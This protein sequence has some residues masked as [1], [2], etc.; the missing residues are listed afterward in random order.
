MPFV[1]ARI[2]CRISVATS[3]LKSWLREKCPVAK[4]VFATKNPQDCLGIFLFQGK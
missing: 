3:A 2:P 4:L 1:Q